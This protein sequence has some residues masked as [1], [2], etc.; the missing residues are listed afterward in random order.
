MSRTV[1]VPKLVRNGTTSGNADAT[2]FDLTDLH[3]ATHGF[4]VD[5]VGARRA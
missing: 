4:G 5:D 2:Q 1:S 3:V